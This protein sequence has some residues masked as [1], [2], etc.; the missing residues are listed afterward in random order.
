MY[1]VPPE[2]RR[3]HR[4]SATLTD[5]EFEGLKRLADQNRCTVSSAIGLVLRSLLNDLA[6]EEFN[7]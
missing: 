4:V 7:V 2:L 5:F 1:I 6:K 3:R